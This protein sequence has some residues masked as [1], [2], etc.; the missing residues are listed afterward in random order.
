MKERAN[1]SSPMNKEITPKEEMELTIDSY[2][3]GTEESHKQRKKSA[4][5]VGLKRM[6][7][8]EMDI[9]LAKLKAELSHLKKLV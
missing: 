6:S 4:K 9:E 7:K 2:N 3:R 5:A 1:C 8:E